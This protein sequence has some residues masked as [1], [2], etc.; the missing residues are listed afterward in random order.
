MYNKKDPSELKREPTK[1]LHIELNISNTYSSLVPQK[2]SIGACHMLS[3]EVLT[4]QALMT[5]VSGWSPY[6]G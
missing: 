2:V 1:L 4:C 3:G 6:G 5:S